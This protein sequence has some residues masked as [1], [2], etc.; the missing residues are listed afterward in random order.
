VAT[1]NLPAP[2]KIPTPPP[3]PRAAFEPAPEAAVRGGHQL[4]SFATSF[5]FHCLIIIVLGLIGYGQHI[6]GQSGPSIQ[7][8]NEGDGELGG[9]DFDLSDAGAK[10]G[11]SELP[12]IASD[13]P[14]ALAEFS[15]TAT[16]KMATLD[17]GIPPPE[18]KI[19]LPGSRAAKDSGGL[20]GLLGSKGSGDAKE[21]DGAGTGKGSGPGFGKGHGYGK[22]KF[23]GVES[24]GNKFVYVFDR[25]FSMTSYD[26]IPLKTAKLELLSSIERLQDQQQFYCVFYN[27][28]PWPY[29]TYGSSRGRPHFAT[30]ENKNRF[31]NFLY[32]MPAEGGTSHVPALE[33]AIRKKPDVIY[34]LT[35]GE[36]KDDPTRAELQ[37]LTR[38][39][40]GG[41]SIHVIQFTLEP[42]PDSTLVQLAKLNRGK[43]RNVDIQKLVDRLAGPDPNVLPLLP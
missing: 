20:G 22:T 24:E 19:E 31:R 27:H 34:L 37:K 13:A 39:N 8:A 40:S 21:G 4:S 26:N 2:P 23:F 32:E 30:S 3:I 25:S 7:V 41:A 12:S 43:H 6:V 5:G 9:G 15:T 29:E 36:E 28:Q 1:A 38:M 17:L 42:R 18:L 16:D 10:P 33:W 14:P 11:E 35:D